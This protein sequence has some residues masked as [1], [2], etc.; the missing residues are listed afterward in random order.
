[1]AVP[2]L[3]DGI[4]QAGS[5]VALLWKPGSAPWTPEVIEPEYAGWRQEQAA[6]HDGVSISDLSHHMSDT[7]IAGRDATRLLAAV[8]ANNYENFA[9]GQA[10]Q[11][12]PVAED[13]NILTD[14]I[15][16]RAAEHEYILSG[17]SPAQEWVRY[18]A[19]QGGWDVSCVTD[20]P[21]GWRGGADPRLFRFQVQGPL[22]DDLVARAFGPLPHT[23]FFHAVPVTLAGREFRALR[24]N[25]AAQAGYEFIGQWQDGAAVKE[26]LMTAGDPLGLVH[27]G[28]LAYP[29]SGVE[30]GWI[31][32][33]VPAVYTGPR[34]ADYRRYLGLYS[35]EGQNPLHGS[36]FSESIEDY[37]VSPWELGYGRSISL[38]HDFIG[39]DALLAARVTVQRAKVT[40]VFDPSDAALAVAPGKDLALSNGRYRVEAGGELAGMAYHTASLDPL[41]AVLALAVLDNRYTAPGTQVTV[42]WGEHPGPGTAPDADLGFPRI[43]ATVAQAPYNEYARTAY[44]AAG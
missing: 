7:F 35:F 26:A 36:F 27:V 11:F 14:G 8:S 16:L 41:G 18:H 43:R 22:A 4:D 23:R 34:L 5:A 21:S 38:G 6:W 33:P 29:T 44:R 28:A 20:P 37:Y 31:A 10:K 19:G 2:S 24:H 3:Q 15:L 30:S 13:G 39:R 25:M 9:V 42:S 12:I 17:V 40:L 32:A 1:M